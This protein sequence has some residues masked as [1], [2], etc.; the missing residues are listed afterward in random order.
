MSKASQD[1]LAQI[2]LSEG[3]G[4][5][6]QVAKAKAFDKIEKRKARRAA[7]IAGKATGAYV[8]SQ[9]D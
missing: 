9:G 7:F 2:L 3:K 8:G 6:K 1:K 4:L 5:S